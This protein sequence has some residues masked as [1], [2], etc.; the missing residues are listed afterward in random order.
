MSFSLEMDR[1]E[2][3]SLAKATALWYGDD[4]YKDLEN[5]V[6]STY[7]MHSV[8]RESCH[9]VRLDGHEWPLS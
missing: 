5:P 1:L 4:C 3:L 6:F 8:I 2:D 7:C 9:K